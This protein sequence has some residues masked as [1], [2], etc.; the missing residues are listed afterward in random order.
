MKLMHHSALPG[1]WRKKTKTPTAYL[2]DQT[3]DEQ[4][5]QSVSCSEISLHT[6]SLAKL[7]E[8]LAFQNKYDVEVTE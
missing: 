3:E 6:E 4:N 8:K 7:H 5:T 1:F 2:Q